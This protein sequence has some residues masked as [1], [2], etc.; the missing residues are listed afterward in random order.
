MIAALPVHSHGVRNTTSGVP[1][2]G[3]GTREGKQAHGPRDHA[4]LAPQT[5]RRNGREFHKDVEVSG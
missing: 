4:N 3:T 2:T 1:L 5:A